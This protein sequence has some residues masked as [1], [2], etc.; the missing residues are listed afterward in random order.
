M[1]NGHG[2]KEKSNPLT[3]FNPIKIISSSILCRA[4]FFDDFLLISKNISE[5]N[6][7]E[8]NR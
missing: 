8:T 4:I 5:D 1:D 3:Y 2:G 7:D 6:S